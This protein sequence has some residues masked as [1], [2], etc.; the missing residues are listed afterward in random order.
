MACGEH[1]LKFVVGEA[2]DMA[3][4]DTVLTQIGNYAFTDVLL[5]PLG[6][7]KEEL[8]ER[9]PIV[10]DLCKNRGF[11]Y[12]PRLHIELYGNTRGT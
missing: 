6:V 5:M 7:T 12:C 2:E 10:S 11:R 4:I 8:A 9:A 3:E 1:Q